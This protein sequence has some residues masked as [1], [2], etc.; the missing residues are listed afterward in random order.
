MI[1]GS[2]SYSQSNIDTISNTKLEEVVVTATKTLRQLS[3]LPM[4]AKLI[5]KDEIAKS[6]SAKLSD[7]LDDQPGI[8]IVPDFGGGNGIQIQGLD[9]QYTLLLIDGSPIIGRQS[10]TLDL[11]RISIGNIEQIEIIKGSS[12]SLYGTDALGGVVNLITSK[13]KDSISAEASYKISTFN[14]NDISVNLGKISQNGDNLNFYFNSFDSNGYDLNDDSIL[15]T[16]EPYKSYTGFL[17]YNFKKNK[18]SYFSSVRIYNENQNFTLNENSYGKNIINELGI[19]T[20]INY[21]KNKNY[22][23]IFENYYT[24][25]K[26][27]EEFRLNQNSIEE[28]FFN[29]SLF[30]SELRSIYTINKKNTLT[31]GLGFYSE[32]LKRNNFYREEV[33]QNSFNYFVQYE[34]FIFENTNYVFGARY[35]QY[36]EY[37]SEFSPRFAIRTQINDNIS[38]KISIG[39]GFKTPDYRQLYFNFSNSISGYS[40]IGFNAAKEIISNLQSLGQISNLIISQDEF[41]GKLKPETSISFNLGFNIKTNKSTVFDINFFRNQ[42]SNL[43]DYKII[44]SKVNGQSIFS[45]YNLNKVYTQG[46]EFNSTSTVF[47]DIEISLGY[48]FLEAKDNDSKNQIKNGEVFAR[49]TPSSP[50]FQIK[51]KDYFGLYNRSKHNFNLKISYAFKDYFDI[52]FKSKYRSKYGLSDSNGNNLLD[53]FDDFVESNL[54]SDI[55][56]SKNYKNYILTFGVEN[57]FDYTDRENIPNYPGRIIYS[58]LNITL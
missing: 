53:D 33:S 50:T 12:S 21:I 56:I 38:S 22:K 23:L 42:I 27:D 55:S 16:V 2:A 36:D 15:N 29:Q 28:S 18:W 1:I 39:K 31:F 47:N 54:I 34:G 7:I 58:K 5:T 35:D 8:F 49:R 52:Y 11:D 37:E 48:Q 32:L 24:N 4:P 57:L 19:N 6:S 10:G 14:T 46:I 51:P 13:T 26:N 17:R 44:A 43:I 25:Y 45:Y 9:S 30:K 40:V 3:T 41:E 20:S